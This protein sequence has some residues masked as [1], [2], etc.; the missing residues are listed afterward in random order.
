SV[1]VL[2]AGLEGDRP[3][4]VLQDRLDMAVSYYEENRDALI[5]V[6]GGKGS[7]EAYT[8]AY[9]MERYLLEKGIPQSHIVKEEHSAST[10]ENFQYS[11]EL[12]RQEGIGPG[13][14]IVYITNAFHS[15]RAGQYAKKAGFSDIRSL[16]APIGIL[17]AP[18]C[19]LREGLAV[20][21]LWLAG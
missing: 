8:E 10:R 20:M 18:P 4:S 3:N 11:L 13:E 15:Y 21:W 6:S 7:D 1:I 14:P 5:V 2:G 9:V 16:P 12:L 19:Y 17:A